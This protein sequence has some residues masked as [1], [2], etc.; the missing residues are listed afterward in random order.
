MSIYRVGEDINLNVQEKINIESI[1]CNKDQ[2]GK[3]IK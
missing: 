1:I 3:N 2:R